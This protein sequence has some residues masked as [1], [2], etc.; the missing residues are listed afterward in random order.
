M[1]VFTSQASTG[2]VKANYS[3]G[4]VSGAHEFVIVS[5]PNIRR[6]SSSQG[7][8]YLFYVPHS[9]DQKTFNYYPY[10][11]AVERGNGYIN[12][13]APNVPSVILSRRHVFDATVPVIGRI[14]VSGHDGQALGSLVSGSQYQRGSW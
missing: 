1:W 13:T 11:F 6:D 12:P 2:G 14:V 10:S 8:L 5:S 4:A 9:A 7:S 3:V